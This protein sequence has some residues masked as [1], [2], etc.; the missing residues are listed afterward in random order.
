MKLYNALVKLEKLH[1]T[2]I[3]SLERFLGKPLNSPIIKEWDKD[4]YQGANEEFLKLIKELK[5][6]NYG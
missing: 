4:I 6:A 5:E 1:N 3:I 2:S